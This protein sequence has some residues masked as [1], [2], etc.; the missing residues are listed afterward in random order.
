METIMNLLFDVFQ[1]CAIFTCFAV[2]AMIAFVAF[3]H[4]EKRTGWFSK[5]SE[6]LF[7]EE[8]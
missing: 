1:F 4:I 7:S 6:Y 8:D 2:P 3:E 5:A